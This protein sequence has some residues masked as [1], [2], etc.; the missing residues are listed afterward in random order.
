MDKCCDIISE[1]C[2]RAHDGIKKIAKTFLKNFKKG[3][4]K[5]DEV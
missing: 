3:I 1:L 5:G 4:D 2:A